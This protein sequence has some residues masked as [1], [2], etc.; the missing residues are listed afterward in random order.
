MPSALTNVEHGCTRGITILHGTL[1][2]QIEINVIMWQQNG[3]KFC[4]C[5]RQIVLQ[6]KNFWCGIPRKNRITHFA[7][8]TLLATK[9]IRYLYALCDRACVAPQLH[10]SQNLAIARQRHKSMLLPGDANRLNA[11]LISP[12]KISEALA[13]CGKPPCRELC[14]GTVRCSDQLQRCTADI[15]HPTPIGI[16]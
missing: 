12:C 3:G 14:S 1:P 16:V 9:T 11:S 15:Y 2:R 6:P 7:N 10:W 8:T 13:Q 4:V 5:I